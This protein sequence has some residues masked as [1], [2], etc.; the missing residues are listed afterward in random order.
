MWMADTRIYVS[1]DTGRTWLPQF[2]ETGWDLVFTDNNH[3]WFLGEDAVYRSAFGSQTPVSDNM[4]R[5]PEEY[6]LFNNFPN[7]FNSSTTMRFSL[8]KP[9][10]VRLKVFSLLGHEIKTLVSEHKQAGEY[11]INWTAKGLPSGIYLY[12]LKAGEYV[13][14]RK[15]ILQR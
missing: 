10:F 4:S 6:G 3:G 2:D 15:M 1:E 11:Q 5:I 7:P 12:R 9:C 13:E 8:P 14:T